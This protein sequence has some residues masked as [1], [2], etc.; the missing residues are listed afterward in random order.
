MLNSRSNYIAYNNLGFGVSTYPTT[1]DLT[2]TSVLL[3][4]N[5]KGVSVSMGSTKSN[6]VKT[7]SNSYI[8]GQND[9]NPI[10]ISTAL[11]EGDCTQ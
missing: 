5:L 7:L 2:I 10:C 11:C 6:P 1:K 9:E 4:N 3:S 8:I